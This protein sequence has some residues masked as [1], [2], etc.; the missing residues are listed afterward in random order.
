MGRGRYSACGGRGK[1]ET[2]HC[3]NFCLSYSSYEFVWIALEFVCTMKIKSVQETAS[4]IDQ[5]VPDLMDSR[6][7]Y[8]HIR[9][10]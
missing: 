6:S 5:G 1:T 8:R 2:W 10:E 7:H 9:E 4:Q 3:K